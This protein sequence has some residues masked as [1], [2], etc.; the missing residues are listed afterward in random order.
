MTTEVLE[1]NW[2]QNAGFRKLNSE[3]PSYLLY[4]FFHLIVVN[5]PFFKFCILR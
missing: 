5:S 4:I 1:K 3:K 2:G